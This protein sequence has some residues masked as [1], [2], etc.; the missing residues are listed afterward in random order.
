M[1]DLGRIQVSGLK[2][3]NRTLR[4]ID[5]DAPK[6][7]RLAGNASAQIV[8]DDAKPRVP[9]GPGRGG[10]A[11][12]SIKAASTRTAAR[13][14]AGGKRFPYFPWL[15]FG[16]SVGPQKSNHRPFIKRG[17]YV[18]AA[19]ADNRERV[20]GELRDQLARIA[21]ESGSGVKVRR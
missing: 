12:S 19:F 14:R 1:S 8:V 3:F 16:G 18:W 20:E 13:V 17:R 9:L 15:D 6:G 11:K 21:R 2:Q 4:Q 5:K 10:H 7:L